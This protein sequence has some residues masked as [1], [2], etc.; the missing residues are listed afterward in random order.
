[1]SVWRRGSTCHWCGKEMRL[2]KIGETQFSPDVF[3]VDH[4]IPVSEGGSDKLTNLVG[5]CAGCNNKR[6]TFGNP[7]FRKLAGRGQ[8]GD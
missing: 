1:M 5:S 3:T 4:L 6:G 7:N 2:A 8:S